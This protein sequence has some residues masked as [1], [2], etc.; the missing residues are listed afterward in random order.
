MSQNLST[1][2]RLAYSLP[3][4]FLSVVGVPLFIYIPKFY[5]D[6]VGVN[7]AILGGIILAARVIDAVTDP[8][9]GL[10]S[11]RTSSRFGRRRPYMALGSIGLSLFLL[12][13]Y[14]PPQASSTLATWWFGTALV[15]LTLFWTIVE[16]PW[17][18]LGP[19]LTFDYDQRTGLFALRDGLMV[20]GTLLA[21]ASPWLISSALNLDPSGPDQRTSFA[22][23]AL[24]YAPLLLATLWWCVVSVQET[25]TST[26]PEKTS[27][28]PGLL[29]ARDNK[30]FL[31]L[32]AAYTIASIGSNLPATLILY[33][34]QYVLGAPSAEIFLLEYFVVGILCLP[35]WVRLA[36]IF[37]KKQAWL[38]A[39][40]VNTGAFLGVFFLGRGDVVLYGLLVALSGVGF[41]ASLALPSAMQ[42]DVID[43]DELLHA[44]RQEGQ[45]IG[46]WSVA[47]KLS[48][49]LGMGL[50]LPLLGLAGYVPDQPQPPQVIAT[51]KVL[52]ALVPC[53]F[54]ILAIFAALKYPLNKANH[55]AIL[56]AIQDRREGR[57]VEDPLQ[58]GRILA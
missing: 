49:A 22:L 11:D 37:G 16:V 51:L 18:S 42:A 15:L 34:V 50:A 1:R 55:Q 19:E 8:A 47:K 41:G 31:I 12:M 3:G 57:P 58:P 33:Y 24:I 27:F 38:G 10:I 6:V 28:W 25:M 40:A 45:Y 2:T 52:Y 53:L 54:N 39:M 30:P 56:A 13:L 4:L 5:T 46:I 48:S 7:M 35:L 17:E 43:Y 29:R 23:F 36:R 20:L 21:V 32:L 14:I 44:K 9:V 26:I